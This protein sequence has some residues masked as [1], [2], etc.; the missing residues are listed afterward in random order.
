MTNVNK[1]KATGFANNQWYSKK[2]NTAEEAIKHVEMTNKDG[3]VICF[4][5]NEMSFELFKKNVYHFST[6]MSFNAELG[7]WFDTTHN[8]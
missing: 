1:Y 6:E 4:K 3:K 7:K 5:R 8:V 2:F